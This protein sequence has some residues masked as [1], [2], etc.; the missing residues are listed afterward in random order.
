MLYGNIKQSFAV[1]NARMFLIFFEHK[2]FSKIHYAGA[3]HFAENFAALR[4]FH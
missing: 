2:E 4:D 1:K 3:I